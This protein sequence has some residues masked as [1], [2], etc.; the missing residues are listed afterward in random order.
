[1]E[2]KEYRHYDWTIRGELQKTIMFRNRDG[3]PVMIE[4]YQ[5][6]SESYY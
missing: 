1:M 4:L 2:E 6:Q 3:L 5:I